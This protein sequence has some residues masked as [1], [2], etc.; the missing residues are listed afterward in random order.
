M[1]LARAF[2]DKTYLL[3]SYDPLSARLMQGA[4]LAAGRRAMLIEQT[5]ATL[6]AALAINDGQCLPVSILTQGISHTVRRRGL[7]PARTALFCPTDA[8]LSCNLPQYP[9]MI[10]QQLER[11]GG[12][13]E[14]VEI[15]VSGFVPMEAPLQW[16]YEIYL[17]YLLA[18]LVQKMTRRLRPRE[19]R[20]GATDAVQRAAADR[21]FDCFAAGGAKEAVLQGIVADFR[22]IPVRERELPQVGIVGDVFVRD[23]EVMNRGLVAEIEGA[24]AE[25]LAIPFCDAL[26]L[27][28]EG[29]FRNQW[30]DG[31]YLDLLQD[32]MAY[33]ALQLF[34]SRLAA[35]AEPVLG[36]K[37]PF[38]GDPAALLGRY[39]FTV[40]H[41]GET[42]ENLLK[43]FYLKENYPQL[44]L[45]VNVNPIFCCPGLISEGLYRKV[46]QDIGLPIV[47]ITY[48]GTQADKNRVLRP[49]LHFLH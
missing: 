19:T 3:P 24:G 20:A 31:R 43:I 2:A 18:G 28:A 42:A 17:A 33:N 38:A 6:Q 23:N 48:D 30:N 9:V 12:G 14:R 32:K 25:A 35:L 27:I 13:L 10:K 15:L 40:R 36:A 37:R 5:P 4:F 39:A 22:A 8:P 1:T 45:I 44:K 47:S 7:D 11:L 34:S 46:E 26:D 29:H 41:A 21:L 49:Y 16:K